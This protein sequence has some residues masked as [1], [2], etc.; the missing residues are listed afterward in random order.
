MKATNEVEIPIGRL[1]EA[2]LQAA[3][4][5][6]WGSIEA[7]VC[8]LATAGLEVDLI[9]RQKQVEQ[10]LS[11]SERGPIVPSNHRTILVKNKLREFQNRFKLSTPVLSVK[12]NFADGELK[13]F[14]VV[15]APEF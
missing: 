3:R 10:V 6:F 7:E 15:T 9:I 8:L 4:P 14:E 5:G 12:G 2:F 1:E 11:T 13:N